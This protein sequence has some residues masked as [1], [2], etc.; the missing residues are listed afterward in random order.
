[1][2]PPIA[3]V[4]QHDIDETLPNDGWCVVHDSECDPGSDHA[5]DIGLYTAESILTAVRDALVGVI[6]DDTDPLRVVEAVREECERLRTALR[7][8]ARGKHYVVDDADEFDGVSDEPAN[9]IFSGRE[10][11]TTSIEVGGI[12]RL[13]LRGEHL[14]WV[15][16]DDDETPQPIEGER[17]AIRALPAAPKE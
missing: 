8:Y 16:G 13:A 17:A 2:P 14:N 15:E 4:E 12:A 3:W 9:W 10:D 1:M 7:F 11:C 6:P 5:A